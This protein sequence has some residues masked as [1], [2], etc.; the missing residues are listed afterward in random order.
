MII[1]CLCT[2]NGAAR[3]GGSGIRWLLNGTRITLA[4]DDGT[5]NP[6]IRT[7]VPNQLVIPSFVNPYN[8][9]YSCG[10][11]T[12]NFAD[13]TSHITLTLAGNNMH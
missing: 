10:F 11:N 9:L 12:N 13:V 1:Y 5:G 8:G 2:R 3:G 4:S 7:V 6:Y